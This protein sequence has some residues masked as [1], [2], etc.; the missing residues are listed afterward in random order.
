MTPETATLEL[1]GADHAGKYLIF[2]L[3]EEEYGV[4]VLK[5]REIVRMM[6]ITTVPHM[7]PHVRG[8]INLRGKV[9][10]VI[11]LRVKF[12][13]PAQE[14][15]E[16]TC[17]VIV[18]VALPVARVMMGIIVDRVAEVLYL[19]SQDIEP[20]PEFGDRVQTDYMRGIAKVKGRVKILID[21]DRVLGGDGIG[22]MP[23]VI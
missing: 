18:E 17:I 16:R 11:D 3:A 14:Y 2:A 12:G 4:P 20:T 1:R 13:F 5:V 23:R 6:D 9:I 15:T 22:V 19:T 7:P 10:P 21:L 8:V